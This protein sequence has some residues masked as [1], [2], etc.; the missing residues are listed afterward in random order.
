MTK[1]V[2]NQQ[3]GARRDAET[4]ALDRELALKRVA[5]M[6]RRVATECAGTPYDEGGTALVSLTRALDR[7]GF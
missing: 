3:E 7:A 6:A 1:I 5:V 4:R 2:L